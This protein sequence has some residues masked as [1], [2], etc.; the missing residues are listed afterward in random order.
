MRYSE[1]K[2]DVNLAIAMLTDALEDLYD[3]AVLVSAD[4]DLIP[5][6]EV[7]RKHIPNKRIALLLPPERGSIALKNSCHIALGTLNEG[8]IKKSQFPNTVIS[9]SGYP[10]LRPSH[11]R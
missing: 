8:I 9:K 6:V 11:W 7:I 1:K 2:S 4:S 5:A 10:L 3:V